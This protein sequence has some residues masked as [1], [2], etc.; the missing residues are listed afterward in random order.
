MYGILRLHY[1]SVP[2]AIAGGFHTEPRSLPLAVLIQSAFPYMQLQSA[3]SRTVNK[4][5]DGPKAP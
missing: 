1:G 3:L 2:R 5:N 4:V